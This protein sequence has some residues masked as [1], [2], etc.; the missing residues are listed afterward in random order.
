MSENSLKIRGKFINKLS[1]KLDDLNDYF[2]LLGQVDKKIFKKINNQI[3]GVDG[4]DITSSANEAKLAILAKKMELKRQEK[5]FQ[6]AIKSLES[7]KTTMEKVKTT[8]V[9]L[10]RMITSISF[11]ADLD[12]LPKSTDFTSLTDKEM[13]TLDTFVSTSTTQYDSL[14]EFKADPKLPPD[15]RDVINKIS[16]E[17]FRIL[18]NKV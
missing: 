4:A 10:S 7:L 16:D 9:D 11:T 14:A 5:K 2:I 17:G 1:T 18:F 13:E 3:G 6:D 8:F 12:D 15:V